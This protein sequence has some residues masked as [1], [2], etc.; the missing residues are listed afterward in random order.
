MVNVIFEIA[1]KEAG[2]FCKSKPALLRN[3]IMLAIFCIVPAQQVSGELASNG[4]LASTF[5]TALET[6]LPFATFYAIVL[7]AGISAMAFPLE[8]ERRTIEYLLSLPLKDSEIFLG[9]ALAAIAAGILGTA[10]IFAAIIGFTLYNAGDKVVWD[11]PVMTPSLALVMFGISPMIVILSTMMIVAVSGYL[12]GV[13]ESYFATFVM[14][15][16]VVGLAMAKEALPVDHLLYNAVLLL[17]LVVLTAVC[18]FIGV[19]SFNRERLMARA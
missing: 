13:R 7:S 15:G 5:S 8:K 14:L 6:Y 11:S 1:K 10:V 12:S 2:S 17:M 9:K 18:Y 19:K 16:L 4:F 3:I